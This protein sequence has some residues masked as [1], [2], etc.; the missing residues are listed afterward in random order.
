MTPQY[1]IHT[2]PT[3]PIPKR[4]WGT[5]IGLLLLVISSRNTLEPPAQSIR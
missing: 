2:V 5:V 4:R 3:V 1:P